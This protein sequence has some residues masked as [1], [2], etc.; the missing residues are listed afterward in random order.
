M[1]LIDHYFAGKAFA[2]TGAGDGIGRALAIRLNRGAC[3]LWLCDINPE[4]LAET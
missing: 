2:I 4:R 3:H 1:A